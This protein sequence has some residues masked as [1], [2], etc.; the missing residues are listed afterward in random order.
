[1]NNEE[2]KA[3]VKE[4]YD[5][6]VSLGYEVLFT[7]LQGSQNYGLDEY[8]DEYWSDI[9][10]KSVVLPTLDDFVYN[11]TPVSTVKIMPNSEEHAEVKDIRVM[12]EM[13]KKENI[14]Y[15]EL[16]Y[17]DYVVINPKYKEFVEE[18]FVHRD[19]ITTADTA[20]FLKCIS[21]MAMEKHKALCHPYP[22]IAWKI[23]KYGFDGK[24]LHHIVRLYDFISRFR[25]L[26]PISACFKNNSKNRLMNY[27]K[28]KDANGEIMNAQ[29]AEF[30][31]QLYDDAIRQMK[32]E[33]LYEGDYDINVC[34]WKFLDE[35]QARIIKQHILETLIPS[36]ENFKYFSKEEQEAEARVIKAN[37]IAPKENIYEYYADDGLENL[38]ADK[39]ERSEFA[40]E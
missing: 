2:I 13:F 23:E 5:Y 12:F 7:A 6:L 22:T 4:H 11:K 29:E 24:Q 10:T 30:L 36:F 18:L 32:D 21:G 19:E 38:D 37:A 17:S 9:D 28:Q 8:T 15:I 33:M 39:G 40:H 35:L 3:R 27:K 31:A 14:S 26:E 1:M 25:N 16:L 20:Q 34:V